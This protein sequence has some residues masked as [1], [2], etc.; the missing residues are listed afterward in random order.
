MV[1]FVY[2][3]S[4]P[5]VNNKRWQRDRFVPQ[6]CYARQAIILRQLGVIKHRLRH[7]P[8]SGT[9]DLVNATTPTNPGVHPKK[10][11]QS[12]LGNCQ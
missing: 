5:I 4:F 1:L 3:I 11:F 9:Q 10:S 7:S 2:K 12:P 6:S 8:D